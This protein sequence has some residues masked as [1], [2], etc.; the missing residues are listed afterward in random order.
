[1]AMGEQ[2][3]LI[4]AAAQAGVKW[5][6]PTEYAGDGMNGELV[7]A[8]PLFHPKRNARKQVE[9]LA[10]THKGLKW[11]GV[12]TNPWM[13]FVCLFDLST[14][15]DYIDTEPNELTDPPYQSMQRGLFG[16]DA[17]N[18][19][20]TLY[21]DSGRFNSTTL[22][23]AGRAIA[24]LLSLP[25]TNTSNPR[26]S[27][28]HYANNFAYVSSFLVSQASLF[29][30][31]QRAT[32]TKESDWM[33]KHSTIEDWMQGCREGMKKGDMRAGAGLTYA[34][35]MGDGKGGNYEEKAKEDREVL[36][37][38][39]E[40]LDEAVARAVQAGEAAPVFKK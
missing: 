25:I 35:Y 37:L 18:K 7:D 27:L 15:S 10:K 4:D 9:E 38:Q 29:G 32:G 17:A 8:V 23:Q 22:P 20:A 26:A 34:H 11:V 3:K 33:V 13:E 30:A 19:T 1:M 2:T 6:L 36:G 24:N 5:I 40:N 21:P 14:A 12:A 39:E 28:S 31:L 16:F